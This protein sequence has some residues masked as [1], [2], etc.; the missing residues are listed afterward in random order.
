[1]ILPDGKP[2]RYDMGPEFTWD[3]KVPARFYQTPTTPPHMP[4]NL[5]SATLAQ[6]LADELIADF[7]ALRAKM[8]FLR[9]LSDAEKKRIL[10]KGLGNMALCEVLH[11]AAE[12]N[13]GKLAGDFPKAEWEADREFLAVF[14]P[15][16]EVGEKLTADMRDT[17]TAAES[18]DYA[19]GREAY[20]DLKRD[21][22]GPKIDQARALMRERHGRRAPATPRPA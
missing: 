13:S 6:T 5:I 14:R 3:G 17:L 1:M 10:E 15:V 2:L 19:T 9:T 4:Q 11:A 7:N 18:D 8:A 12:E 21:A 16:V 22:V 20:D